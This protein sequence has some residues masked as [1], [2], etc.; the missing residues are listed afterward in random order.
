MKFRNLKNDRVSQIYRTAIS[1]EITTGNFNFMKQNIFNFY[2]TSTILKFS[3][4]KCF[5]PEQEII[6]TFES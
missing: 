4:V 2:D 3:N 6:R 1:Q 5:V